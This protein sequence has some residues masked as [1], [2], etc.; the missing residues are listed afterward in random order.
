MGRN[1]RAKRDRKVSDVLCVRVGVIFDRIQVLH[2]G[3]P[4]LALGLMQGP[5]IGLILG[6]GEF[7]TLKFKSGKLSKLPKRVEHMKIMASELTVFLLGTYWEPKKMHFPFN[8]GFHIF[9]TLHP[10]FSTRHPKVPILGH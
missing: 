10:E 1:H 6:A 2:G 7:S 4:G 8:V 9:S 3:G 5:R